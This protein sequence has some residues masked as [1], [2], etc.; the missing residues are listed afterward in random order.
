MFWF[1]LKSEGAVRN[2]G[3]QISMQSS[4]Q[5]VAIGFMCQNFNLFYSPCIMQ[6]DSKQ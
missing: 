2:L 5:L 3:A 1:E 6:I 4:A